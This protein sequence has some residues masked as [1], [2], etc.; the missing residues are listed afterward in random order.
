MKFCFCY[1]FESNSTFIINSTVKYKDFMKLLIRS[2]C[3]ILFLGT[4]IQL[5]AQK[6]NSLPLIKVEGNIF[7]NEK[8][9][10]IVF[11]GYNSS[12]PDKLESQGQ[13]TASYFS[14][15]K[16]WGSNIVRFPI[17]PE[18]WRKRGKDNYLDLIDKGI[19][20]AEQEGMYVILDWH[21]IGNLR[22]EVFFHDRYNTTK[23]E[24]FTFWKLMSEKY[25]NNPT[26]AFFEL[27]NE[28]TIYNNKLGLCSWPQWK[29]IMEEVILIC[30]AN[31][32]KN[33]P[34]VAGFN[35]AY[36]LSVVKNEPIDAEGIAYVSHPY[37]QK[38]DKPWE[39]KWEADW[40][41]VA[42]KY[43]VILTEIGYCKADSEGAHI[44][45]IDDGYFVQA[46]TEYTAK[47]GISFVV[48]VFD[49]NWSPMLI[50]DWSFEPTKEGKVWKDK[51]LE[52]RSY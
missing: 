6:S 52:M 15:I 14:E 12:D 27:F 20:W 25:G 3:V 4:F 5:Q 13:W 43:P 31:G 40:G 36:D 48:W 23:R 16:N 18:A 47:K 51:M 22:S 30:R 26:V 1:T 38:R 7:V 45:V 34:L 24:T 33:I 35:W 10:T 2:F 11:R 49:P 32:A 46:I 19:A 28:P 39:E 8:G 29:E 17:H 44:P 50:K 21:S 41:F 37:P 9:E 42:D